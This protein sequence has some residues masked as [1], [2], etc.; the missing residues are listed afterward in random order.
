[1][2]IQGLF[3]FLFTSQRVSCSRFWTWDVAA[4]AGI[5]EEEP[6]GLMLLPPWC[7]AERKERETRSRRSSS[8]TKWTSRSDE[9]SVIPQTGQ[10]DGSNGDFFRPKL[11]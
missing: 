4:G 3:L 8:C 10:H 5:P 1:M 2:R 9:R 11:N 7:D 6:D